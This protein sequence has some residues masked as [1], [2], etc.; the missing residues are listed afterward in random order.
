MI[1]KPIELSF[2]G[3]RVNLPSQKTYDQLLSSLLD[4][5]GHSPVD[6][7]ELERSHG[8]WESY[9]GQAE[10]LAGPSGFMLF[11]LVDHGAWMAKVGSFSRSIRV[12]LGNPALAITMLQHDINAG[13]FAPV[14]MLLVEEAGNSRLMYVKP[15]SLMVVEPNAEL[16]V[17]AQHLDEKLLA[18]AVKVTSA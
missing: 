3:V 18:L 10:S 11:A 9:R 5:L 8:S 4:D 2:E 6:L 7:D 13:L 17:A 16:E 14:E 12:V 1:A 15:S